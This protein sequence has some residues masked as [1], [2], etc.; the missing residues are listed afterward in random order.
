LI[1][2]RDAKSASDHWYDFAIVNGVDE[3]KFN[4]ALESQT[5]YTMEEVFVQDRLS[6]KNAQSSD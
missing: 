6:W 3:G 1:A 2:I 5:F 4:S